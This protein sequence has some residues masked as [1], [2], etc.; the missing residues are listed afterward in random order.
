VYVGCQ[1]LEGLDAAW[2]RR[3]VHRDIKPA[4]LMVTPTGRVKI[5]DFGVAMDLELAT[6]AGSSGLTGTPAYMAPEQLRGEP[7]DCRTDLY[8]LGIT[9][10]AMVAGRLPFQGPSFTDYYRQHLEQDPPW[11]E[12]LSPHVAPRLAGVLRKSLA[13]APPDR[14]G[15][16][17][18]M[19]SAL[20]ASA[21]KGASLRDK[22]APPLTAATVSAPIRASR[23]AL[24]E[25]G[26][27]GAGRRAGWKVV[28]PVIGVVVVVAAVVGLFVAQ[29]RTGGAA[30]QAT[31]PAATASD[32]GTPRSDATLFNDPP[33]SDADAALPRKTGS[34]SSFLL[35]RAPD[36]TF[37]I[38]KLTGDNAAAATAALPLTVSDGV[39]GVDVSIARRAQTGMVLLACRHEVAANSRYQMTL[40]PATG[41]VVLS[42]VMPGGP[43]PISEAHDASAVLHADGTPDRLE[44]SCNGS[45]LSGR[46]NGH[47]VVTAENGELATGGWL[48]GAGA[49]GAAFEAHFSNL[50]VS[51]P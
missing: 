15:T 11:I 18:E 30:A 3:I 32:V 34:P 36:N 37:A 6:L 13:K 28:A 9:L 38:Q 2:A 43:R 27:S 49:P 50:E 25:P 8:A 10:Y 33:A 35:G 42:Q 14:F 46:V 7:V 26:H 1:V 41:R 21:E 48:I 31:T 45:M 47:E 29:P 5:M 16:P 44:L 51:R 39:M 40:A 4:N 20:Q 23:E 24:A 19:L 12:D 17:A 22:H